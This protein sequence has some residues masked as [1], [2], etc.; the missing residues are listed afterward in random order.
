L[1]EARKLKDF[2]RGRHAIQYSKDFV[3]TNLEKQ[4]HIRTVAQLLEYD[5]LLLAEANDGDAAADSCRAMLN[6]ARS[7]GDEPLLLSQLVRIALRATAVRAV[8]RT[9]AQTEPS[10]A[11]LRDLQRL[12]EEEAAAP[13]L[14]IALRGERAGL[15]RLIEA[16]QSGEVSYAKLM[17]SMAGAGRK[18]DLSALDSVAQRLPGAMALQRAALLRYMTE[19]VE[20]A[21]LPS[22]Q[23][24]RRYRELSAS[25]QDRRPLVRLL[26][27]STGTLAGASNRSLAQLRCTLV[28][29][30][31]ERFRKEHH[32]RPEN[33]AALVAAGLLKDVPLDP[34][35]GKPLRW[36]RL[37]DRLA[38]YSV[39]ADGNEGDGN[40]ERA[41][42]MAA[43][44]DLGVQLW[45]VPHR[46]QPPRPQRAPAEA[47]LPEDQQG[48]PAG[49]VN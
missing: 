43:G 10:P 35:D 1:A 48:P 33:C 23:Q 13:L 7:L 45:D 32:R 18:N 34:F 29:V 16:V 30:A 14:R 26:A 6:A 21:K 8:E 49:P 4:Q 3:S 22:D 41:R 42:P 15:D 20:A 24:L 9:L 28:L 2:P 12:L 31:A 36:R 25:V 44:T 39:G 47:E 46:R 11:A 5:V 17:Q 27:P 38:C 37:K 19:A 40:N